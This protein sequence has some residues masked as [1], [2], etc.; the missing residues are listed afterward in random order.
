MPLMF[1]PEQQLRTC[2]L[3][4]MCPR[5][6]ELFALMNQALV[7]PMPHCS[8][9]ELSET[10]LARIEDMVDNKP[11][12]MAFFAYQLQAWSKEGYLPAQD[13]TA[14]YMMGRALHDPTGEKLELA[15]S[16]RSALERLISMAQR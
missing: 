9:W 3:L 11:Q 14:L 10:L 12:A 16:T 2:A 8:G 5:V 1:T 4:V 7:Q 15:P 13:I 6:G